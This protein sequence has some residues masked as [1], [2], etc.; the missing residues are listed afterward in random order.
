M[1]VGR[2]FLLGDFNVFLKS[3]N[4]NEVFN[5]GSVAVVCVKLRFFVSS[6]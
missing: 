6:F 5:Y 4:D 2:R 1:A 3:S